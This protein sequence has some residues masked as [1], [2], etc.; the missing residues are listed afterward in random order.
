MFKKNQFGV[1]LIFTALM[2]ARAS[3]ATA[4][5]VQLLTNGGFETGSFAGWTP[6]ILAG[7]SGALFIDTPG[8][9]TPTSGLPTSLAG[10]SPH[11]A[12][13]AVTDMFSPG[14]YSLT[15]TFFVP[16]LS[17]G[18][19]LSFDLFANDTGGGP[20]VH[21]S[22]LDFTSGGT[23]APNQH[24]RVDILTAA[25]SPFDT[26]AGVILSLVAPFVDP[27]PIPNPFTTY[28]FSPAALGALA[29]GGTYQIRFGEVDNRGFLNMGVDNVSLTSEVVPE[30]TSMALF[31]LTALGMGIGIRRRRRKDQPLEET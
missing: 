2:F 4:A 28:S 16:V 29:P 18:L 8:T 11:G 30:P 13:Y 31:G 3:S 9:T 10:G 19:T 27:G 23:L 22:G 26:G 12:F 15:Q 17:S 6:S 25:A 21:P 14:T 20:F 5:P 7:S 1:A 24:V